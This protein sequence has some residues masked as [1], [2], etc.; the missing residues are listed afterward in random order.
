MGYMKIKIG[1]AYTDEQVNEAI[2]QG[3]EESDRNVR[4]TDRDFAVDKYVGYDV[5]DDFHQSE[6]K[7]NH[8]RRKLGE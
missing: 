8:V 1:T 7:Q 5:G 4:K 3:K 2:Q 6:N